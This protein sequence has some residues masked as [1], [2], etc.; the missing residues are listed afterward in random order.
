MRPTQFQLGFSNSNVGN[1]G[2]KSTIQIY[3]KK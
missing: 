1:V 3:Y 2:F